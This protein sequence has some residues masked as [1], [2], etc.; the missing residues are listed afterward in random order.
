MVLAGNLLFHSVQVNHH[1][2]IYM[3]YSRH[4]QERFHRVQHIFRHLRLNFRLKFKVILE[5]ITSIC[6]ITQLY[7]PYFCRHYNHLLGQMWSLQALFCHHS[8][9]QYFPPFN[10]RWAQ[11]LLRYCVPLSQI[12]EQGDHSP[13]DPHLQST[14]IK[15]DIRIQHCWNMVISDPYKN[16]I[17]FILGSFS[18]LTFTSI[19]TGAFVPLNVRFI[20]FTQSQ[21]SMSFRFDWICDC[22]VIIINSCT[23]GIIEAVSPSFI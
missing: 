15:I 11:S 4:L 3:Y 17:F 8:P 7:F 16:D 14:G 6:Y 13:Q 2:Y 12:F 10:E 21:T 5:M 22:A 19:K 23:W 1:S 18:Y 20:F 9:S